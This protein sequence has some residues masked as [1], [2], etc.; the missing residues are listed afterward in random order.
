M[1]MIEYSAYI[2]V[3]CHKTFSE[4]GDM[5]KHQGKHIK[6]RLFRCAVWIFTE[7]GDLEKHQGKLIDWSYT[8]A[9]CDKMFSESVALNVHQI[10]HT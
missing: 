4:S 8:C 9:V 3:V 5:K 2:C 10:I 1:R 7:S 6:G